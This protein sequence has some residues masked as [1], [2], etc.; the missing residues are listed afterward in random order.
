MGGDDTYDI[1]PRVASV[2][3]RSRYVG[4]LPISVVKFGTKRLG[5]KQLP[6]KLPTRRTSTDIITLKNRTLSPL[7]ERFIGCAR[8]VAR[9]LAKMDDGLKTKL[10]KGAHSFDQS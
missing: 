8:E 6:V 5:L 10:P 3:G 1:G 4:V 9:P 7:A 2:A